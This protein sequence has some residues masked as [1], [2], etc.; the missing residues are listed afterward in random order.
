M[1]NL[2]GGHREKLSLTLY[3]QM[4]SG[5]TPERRRSFFPARVRPLLKAAQ[6][7]VLHHTKTQGETIRQTQLRAR[8][9]LFRVTDLDATVPRFRMNG[10]VVVVKICWQ[11]GRIKTPKRGKRAW[12]KCRGKT[13]P[14]MQ[15]HSKNQQ[16]TR[17]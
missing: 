14:D 3:C 6:E 7:Y 10:D 15:N 1:G 12:K 8:C 2:L 5:R 17:F 16:I 13:P 4:P 11:T 9:I